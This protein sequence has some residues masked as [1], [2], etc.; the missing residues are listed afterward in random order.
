MSQE[1]AMSRREGQALIL[2][3]RAIAGLKNDAP[4]GRGAAPLLDIDIG[5]GRQAGSV[6]LLAVDT[7]D[8]VGDYKALRDRGV[9]FHGVCRRQALGARACCLKTCMATKCS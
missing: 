6:P 2:E 9:M 8:C 4:G 5:H 1:T 3:G 7:A